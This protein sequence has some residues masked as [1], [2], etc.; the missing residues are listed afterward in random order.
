MVTLELDY[1]KVMNTDKNSSNVTYST[2][3]IFKMNQKL[4]IL[5]LS[6]SIQKNKLLLY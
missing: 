3:K 1:R 2:M 4:T 6:K 5:I